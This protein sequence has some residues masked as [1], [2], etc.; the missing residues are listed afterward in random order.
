MLRRVIK[1]TLY[2]GATLALIYFIFIIGLW[3]IFEGGKNTLCSNLIYQEKINQNGHYL[4]SITERDCGATTYWS[5][6]VIVESKQWFLP[7][8]KEILVIRGQPMETGLILFWRDPR[9]LVVKLRGQ[10]KI[11][12]KESNWRDVKFEYE[13][14]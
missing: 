11:Y 7:G 5:T 4:V 2:L 8:A 12:S 9:T 13:N 1:I 3:L 14:Y 6:H 10:S